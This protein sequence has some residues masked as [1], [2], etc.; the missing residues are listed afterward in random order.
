MKYEWQGLTERLVV[1][2][3]DLLITLDF[4]HNTLNLLTQYA[5]LSRLPKRKT[6]MNLQINAT[7]ILIILGFIQNTL[8]SL[9]ALAVERLPLG[10]VM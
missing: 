4:T 2:L 6:L 5:S 3:G 7:Y 8:N 1:Q 9:T 10:Q